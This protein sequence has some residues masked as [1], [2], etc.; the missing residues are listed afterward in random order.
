MEA[1]IGCE[2]KKAPSEIFKIEER[3]GREGGFKRNFVTQ[4]FVTP[5]SWIAHVNERE[6]GRDDFQ[7]IFATQSFLSPRPGRDISQVKLPY[8]V[9]DISQ[10]EKNRNGGFSILS[11]NSVIY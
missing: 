7:V 6:I 10:V 5:L 3:A 8:P 4:S 2:N 11:C 9:R 1:P